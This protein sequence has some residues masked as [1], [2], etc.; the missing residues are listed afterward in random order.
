MLYTIS[1]S[2]EYYRESPH[3]RRLQK[4]WFV[5]DPMDDF[6]WGKM[7]YNCKLKEPEIKVD[8][9]NDEVIKLST[10][11]RIILHNDEIKI[12]DWYIE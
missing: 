4:I 6:M 8:M 7:W 2:W 10:R 5:F 1:T 12:Y 3:T 9:T 11:F